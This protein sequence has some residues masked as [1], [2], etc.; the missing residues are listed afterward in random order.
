MNLLRRSKL[1]SNVYLKSLRE[2]RRS[3]LFFSIGGIALSLYV[4]LFYPTIRDAT[5]FTKFLAELFEV[6]Q[7]LMGDVETFTTAEG[8]L[9]T[10]M[11]TFMGPLVVSVFAIL[12][13]TAAIAG[14]EES[15]TLDQLLANP[16]T[17]T[18]LLLQKAAAMLT[19]LVVL[20][21]SIWLGLVGGA[22]LAGFDL[23][24]TGTTQAVLSLFVLGATLGMIALAL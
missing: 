17:R 13:G 14:E 12:K 7:S 9:N 3:L 18:N 4:T 22:L 21:G 16:I 11:F 6:M 15:N 2:Y 10:E 23:S 8:F 24:I 20:S 5:G 1:L 19:S